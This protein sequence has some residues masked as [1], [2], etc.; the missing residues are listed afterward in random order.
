MNYPTHN[1]KYKLF[2]SQHSTAKPIQ[3]AAFNGEAHSTRSIQRQSLFNAQH[4][5]A[6]PIQRAA[7]NAEGNS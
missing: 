6:K 2:N 4:S 1:F 7:F 5:T 3:R